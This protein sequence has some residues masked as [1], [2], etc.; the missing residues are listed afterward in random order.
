LIT[1][2]IFLLF[3]GIIFTIRRVRDLDRSFKES[4]KYSDQLKEAFVEINQLKGLLPIC[5][6]CKCIRKKDNTWE[7]LEAYL[8]KNTEVKFSHS[9]CPDCVEKHHPDYFKNLN[10]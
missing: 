8:S 6:H 9:I 2:S 4:Q 3:A 1:L 7:K 5:Q 10:L